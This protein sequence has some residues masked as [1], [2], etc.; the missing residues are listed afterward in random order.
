MHLA[1][2]NIARAKYPLDAPEIKEFIDNLDTVNAIAEASSGF[3]WR[4]I[5][6]TSN[7]TDIQAFGDSNIIV[8]MSI[9]SSI[10]SLKDFMFKTNHR[11]FMRRKSE[12]FDSMTEAS[13][14][15]WWLEDGEIPTVD[16]AIVRLEHLRSYGDSPYAFSFKVP[17]NM[18]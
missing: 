9:W 1:Q 5:G 3:V 15:L 14:V 2:L 18:S 10:D 8:N 4:L 7:A 16:E 12:W 13:Y 11:D 17:F 6:E